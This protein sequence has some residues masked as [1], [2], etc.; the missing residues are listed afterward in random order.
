MKKYLILFFALLFGAAVA[1]AQPRALGFRF[2]WGFEASY[3]HTIN[4]GFIEGDFGVD[5]YDTKI[6]GFKATAVYDFLLNPDITITDRGS[7]QF[8][9]GPGISFGHIADVVN[10][11]DPH[12]SL[13][14][15]MVGL[16]AQVGVDYTFWFPLQLALDLRPVFGMHVNDR[17]EVFERHSEFYNYGLYGFIPSLSV[18]YR[19]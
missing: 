9:A 13:N 7:W 5:F 18:R 12:V 3:Q 11:Y 4:K 15:T 10:Y 17:T 1:N 8:Y 2:G 19:F 6:P 16:V 14:G